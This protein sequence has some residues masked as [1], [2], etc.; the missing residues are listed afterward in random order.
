MIS[1]RQAAISVIN[2]D[3]DGIGKDWPYRACMESCIQD[4]VHHA[5]GDVWIHTKMVYDEVLK[6]DLGAGHRLAALH[7]DVAKP[8]TR[9]EAHEIEWI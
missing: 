7:H 9:I 4:P 5:E 2:Y 6:C 3:W 8:Q 1:I